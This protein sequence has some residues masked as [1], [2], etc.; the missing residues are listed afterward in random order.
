MDG[1]SVVSQEL[2]ESK[3]FGRKRFQ[4]GAYRLDLSAAADLPVIVNGE[5]S[6][7]LAAYYKL[8][9]SKIPEMPDLSLGLFNADKYVTEDGV[10]MLGGHWR[11]RSAM[12]T[13]IGL[14]RQGTPPGEV[15]WFYYDHDSSQDAD[16]V[17]V[18][19]LFTAVKWFWTLVISARR[20]R[21]SLHA[22][23][24]TIRSG[25]PIPTLTRH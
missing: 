4:P 25:A 18:F 13:L 9:E 23:W 6:A 24:M 20:N 12:H 2:P 19:S 11:L 14:A 10:V 17:H 16:E 1:E 8:S 21:W 15:M 5:A 7:F 22:S 3:T